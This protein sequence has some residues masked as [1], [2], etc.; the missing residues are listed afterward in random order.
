MAPSK[1]TPVKG[2][3]DHADRKK[4]KSSMKKL[5]V[6]L[7]TSSKFLLSCVYWMVNLLIDICGMDNLPCYENWHYLS[8]TDLTVSSQ[9]MIDYVQLRQS[10][11]V[12]RVGY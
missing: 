5:K 8:L 11:S 2:I 3:E 6:S 9:S 4:T 12:I 1:C 10:V 7:V